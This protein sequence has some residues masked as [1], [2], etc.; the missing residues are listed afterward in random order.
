MLRWTW[1]VGVLLL[2]TGSWACAGEK[3]K[4]PSEN[5][6]KELIAQLVSPN[7]EPKLR[8]DGWREPKGYDRDKQQKVIAAYEKLRKIGPKAFPFLIE[9]FEDKRYCLTASD[10]G[11]ASM[12]VSVGHACRAIIDDQVQPY[13]FW[14]RQSG[15]PR[16]KPLRP[17]K[18]WELISR[19]EARKWWEKNKEKT[20]Y[21]LQLENLDWVIAEEAKRPREFEDK[22]RTYLQEIRKEL[23]KSGKPLT[24]RGSQIT[25]EIDPP[26]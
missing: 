26:K 2:S 3:P 20:L 9:R 13:G 23:V 12:N 19:K 25:P 15:D 4:P 7:P 1:L 22:E 16:G 14:P 24:G 11:V 5:E 6:I 17:S 21:Q 18:H 10:S 8:G